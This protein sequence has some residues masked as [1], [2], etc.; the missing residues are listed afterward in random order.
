MRNRTCGIFVAAI[1]VLLAGCHQPEE[2]PNGRQARLLAAENADLQR[3]LAARQVEIEALQ[4]R[5]TKELRQ[6]DYE[7]IRCKARIAAL[8]Q[9]LKTKID[10]RVTGVTAAVMDENAKL[11]R[12]V[13]ELQAQV[14]KLKKPPEQP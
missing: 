13:E 8:Q 4:Q 5:H 3:Q 11:R 7:L 10:E 12:Q 2:A 9:E 1:L 6:R 14:E